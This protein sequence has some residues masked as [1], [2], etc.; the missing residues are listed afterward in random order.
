MQEDFD[1]INK[2]DS[3]LIKK[4]LKM[5]K[6]KKADALFNIQ[7]DFIINGPPA[8]IMHLT[9]LVK[10]FVIHGTVPAFLLLCTLLPLVKDNLG[11]STSS[12]NYRAIASGSLLLKL[13]DIVILLLEG[14]KLACDELQFGFQPDSG[15]VMCSWA[16]SS[17][18][19]YFN[20]KGRAVYGC[21]MDLSKAFDMVDWNELFLTMRLRNV[22]PVFLR[23]LM[24]IYR[25]QQC[26]VKWGQ[27]HSY[28]F[29]VS[30]G[31]RQVAISSPNL[32]S[33]YINGLI[34]K[35]RRSGL[36]C[37]IG[38][39]FMG[40]LG[41]ADDILLLSASRTGLQVMVD[42]C[43]KFAKEK[44]LKFSTDPN[45]EKSKTKC[46][47]FSKSSR[48]RHRVAPVLLNSDP[49]PWVSQVKHLGNVLQNDNSM[50]I[51]CT[52]KRGKFIGKA[53][54]LLQEFHFVKD[55]VLMKIL[56]IYTTSFYG[57][58]LW[59]LYSKEVDRLYKAWNVT[60]RKALRLPNT[61]H[62][63]LI[64]PLS[65]C[66]HP[67]VMLSSR[68]AKFRDTMMNSNKLMIRLLVKLFED[69]RRTV[70]GSNLGRIRLEVGGGLL[71]PANIKK[72]LKYSQVMPEQEW[73]I[74]AVSELL[75]VR[76]GSRTV[77][78]LSASEVNHFIELICSG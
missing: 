77:D 31:V 65:G 39:L 48:D 27:S 14:E 12:Q 72:N 5:M 40:C 74:S 55:E 19:D 75:E 1:Q 17:V 42:I 36:G 11:D 38:T 56:N 59:D 7:S 67:K 25:Y 33:V 57:S 47:V 15:T 3:N 34:I 68:L 13:I 76:A 10:S 51:D 46:I 23:V 22:N 37:Y 78:G 35:L 20:S 58:G 54:S 71:T 62:R 32:F 44:N 64:E 43:G 29:S 6:S 63:Y 60:I 53:N 18:I 45:P 49:L 21:A 73:R 9:N 61:T 4:A 2:I 8:L 28:M 70:L 16:A 24:C 52:L 66:I 69:D 30:N 50:K 26:N 41:Y